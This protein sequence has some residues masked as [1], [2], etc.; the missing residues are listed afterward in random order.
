MRT[1]RVRTRKRMTVEKMYPLYIRQISFKEIYVKLTCLC[2][3]ISFYVLCKNHIMTVK[4]MNDVLII[5]QLLSDGNYRC[6]K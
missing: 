6:S 5:E 2:Q 4:N 1:Q 3:I